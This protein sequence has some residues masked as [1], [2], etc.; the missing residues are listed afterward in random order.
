M[1][2]QKSVQT[3]EVKQNNHSPK[4]YQKFTQRIVHDTTLATNDF[5]GKGFN[6]ENALET[7]REGM[8]A[9]HVKDGLQSMLAAQMLS[10]HQ[11]Q[12]K[13]MIYANASENVKMQ[14]YYTN[15]AIK[16]SSCFIQQANVFAKLQGVCG[17]KIIVERV[18]VHKG[19]QAI[20]GHI[21]GG[22]VNE[23]KE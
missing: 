15:A 4:Q 9:L 10:I 22:R 13:S 6:L 23:E 12:Q 3:K 11:L 18:D 20:V 1:T 14:Q 7:S 21:Q 5:R 16:L 2:I 17:Q 8:E 19:G